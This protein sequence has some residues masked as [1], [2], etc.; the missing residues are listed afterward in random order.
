MIF[1][2]VQIRL[3]ASN[4]PLMGCGP[5]PDWLRKK[6]IYAVDTFDDN[7]CA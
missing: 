6:P 1:K 4:E 7:M 2:H 5:L 3:I